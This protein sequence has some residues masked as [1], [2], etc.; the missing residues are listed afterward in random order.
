LPDCR[1]FWVCAT[2]AGVPRRALWVGVIVGSLLNLIN[3]GGA[4]F[5]G[6]HINWLKLGLTYVIP[7]C[8]ATYGAVSAR[9]AGLRA[10]APAITHVDP[11]RTR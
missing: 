5:G 4:L 7:Y 1:L 10:G 6:G 9:I 11:T 3:Q 2:T 8:V